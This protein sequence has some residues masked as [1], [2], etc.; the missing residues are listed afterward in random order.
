MLKKDSFHWFGC[1]SCILN[2]RKAMTTTPVLTLPD[3]S[4]T[5]VLETDA[6]NNR[7]GAVLMQEGRPLAF[8][9]KPLNPRSI[10]GPRTRKKCWLS[11]K[12]LKNGSLTC[13]DTILSS[14]LI[15]KAFDTYWNSECTRYY[16]K[17]GLL[18]C[19]D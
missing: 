10:D 19:W 15:T 4:K 1:I 13:K 17:Y 18:N 6:C 3:F 14:R 5:F 8:L 2:L 12:Q 11:R 16:T 9:S 7:I